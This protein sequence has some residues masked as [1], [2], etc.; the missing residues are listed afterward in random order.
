MLPTPADPLVIEPQWPRVSLCT[1]TGQQTAGLLPLLMQ[2]IL[3]QTYPRQQ[4]EWV[5]VDDGRDGRLPFQPSEQQL[6][7]LKLRYERLSAAATVGQQ[8]NLSHLLSTGEIVVVMDVDAYYPPGRVEHAVE[9]LLG[10]EA[11]VAGCSQ[12]PVLL[13]AQRQLWLTGASGPNQAPAATLAYKRELLQHTG[14]DPTANTN[15][16][17]SLLQGGSFVLEPLDANFT[18]LGLIAPGEQEKQ[19]RLL[20]SPAAQPAQP[21]PEAV[22]QEL[23]EQLGGVLE[24]YQAKLSPPAAPVPAPV[25]PMPSAW[26][27]LGIHRAFC[28]TMEGKV[29]RQARIQQRLGA[30]G[31]TPVFFKATTPETLP[32]IIHDM[33]IMNRPTQ[34]ACLTSHLRLMQYLANQPEPEECYLIIEDDAILRESFNEVD[35][36]QSLPEQWEI[37][38]LGS[39]NPS[40]VQRGLSLLQHGVHFTRWNH[41]FWAT[42][43]Y[44]IKHQAAERISSTFLDSEARL[45]FV[46]YHRPG[47]HLADFLLYE[48]A[49]TYTSCDPMVTF[50]PDFNSD[51]GYNDVTAGATAKAARFVDGYWNAQATLD[52]VRTSTHA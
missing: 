16:D 19:Q 44:L 1:V 41:D 10:S 37:I 15:D 50:D 9:Q 14:W 48:S 23:F 35:F 46:N 29:E 39:N 45:N 51:I 17:V 4:L 47:C 3:A 30:L 5:V 34:L 40:T 13:L 43:G 6:Q 32:K 21:L 26:N 12:Q 31:I 36:F 8:R 25:R 20:A 18:A 52:P 7:G 49:I 2:Q 28:I 11:L 38:Q 27:R 22:A 33:P 24:A 42:F